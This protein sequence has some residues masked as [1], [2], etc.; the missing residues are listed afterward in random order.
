M[1]ITKLFLLGLLLLVLILPAIACTDLIPKSKPA[2]A[3]A[4]APQLSTGQNVT[5]YY[6]FYR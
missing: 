2:V 3:P 1:K 5:H 4:P 6:R